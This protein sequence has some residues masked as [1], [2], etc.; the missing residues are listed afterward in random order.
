MQLIFDFPVTPRYSFDN[1]V[2]CSGNE[3][4]YHFARRL[5]KPA[6]EE[7]LLYLYGPQG[8]GKTHLLMAVGGSICSSAGLTR[9]PCVSFKEV[10][11]IYGGEYPAEELSRLADR[12][13]GAPALLVDD[14]HLIPDQQSVR[15]ELWQLFN[16]FNNAGRPIVVTGLY[17][18]R[19]LPSLDDHLISRLMWGLV[20]KVDISD[21]DSRRLILKKLAEDRQVVLP[22]DVVDYLLLHVRRD[23]P[24]L[25]AALDAVARYSTLAKRKI[26]LR[27]AREAM[28]GH[29]G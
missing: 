3:T 18:P 19:D 2:V 6:R 10:D 14:I 1:F 25:T 4:A 15:I 24:S 22:A 9:I 17:P 26:S 11:E 12:F 29:A 7:H 16:D 23:V 28:A 20:A 27:L 5:V 8:S 13:K 21:D